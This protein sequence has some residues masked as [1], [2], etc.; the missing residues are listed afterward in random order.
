MTALPLTRRTLLSALVAG[1]AAATLPAR[2]GAAAVAAPGRLASTNTAQI[3]VFSFATATQRTYALTVGGI[4]RVGLGS[5]KNNSLAT[6]LDEDNAA[7]YLALFKGDGSAQRS[8]RIPRELAFVTGTPSWNP[9]AARIAFSVDE[10]DAPTDTRVERTLVVDAVTGAVAKK[11]TGWAH[12]VWARTGE[13]VL[14]NAATGKLVSFGTTLV[15]GAPVG[16]TLFVARTAAYD[17]SADGRYVVHEDDA[18]D[19]AAY[20]RQTGLRWT[21]VTSVQTLRS[22]SL[23]P[24]GRFVSFIGPGAFSVFPC[25][26]AFARGTTVTY[27]AARDILPG[28]NAGVSGRMAWLS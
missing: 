15:K 24:D 18:G 17:V 8:L 19:I 7:V 14:A 9:A 27:D 28:T 6:S 13:L 25:A 26:V 10:Y 21:A 1:T 3:G 2:P 23:S 5:A 4:E 20:D 22:P 11:F 16:V 12:P